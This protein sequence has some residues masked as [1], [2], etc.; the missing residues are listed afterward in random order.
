MVSLV[1]IRMKTMEEEKI[2]IFLADD[3]HVFREGIR[4]ILE[5]HAPMKVVG[6]AA[7]GKKLLK[8]LVGLE[9]EVLLL[10]ID[11]PDIN[12]LDLMEVIS[13]KYPLL[14]VLV[15]SSHD[16]EHYIHHMITNG[17]KGYIL[18]SCKRD[19]LILAIKKVHAGEAYLDSKVSKKFFQFIEKKEKNAQRSAK[20]PLT[21]RE[22]EILKLVAQGHTN[23]EI[24]SRLFIS[25]RTVDTHR[26]NMMVKLDLHNA[27]A[28]TLYASANGYLNDG[29]S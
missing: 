27:A 16:N 21:K 25:H 3:H 5:L 29:N 22:I 4:I 14:P 2:K 12:G 7:T 28:L 23:Q 13:S 11:M 8:D 10:D 26:R 15:F 18:K 1:M 17:A 24:G 20:T 19:E 6:E 9:V